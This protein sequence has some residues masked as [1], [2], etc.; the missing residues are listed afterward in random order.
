[1]MELLNTLNNLIPAVTPPDETT[2]AS[3]SQDKESTPAPETTKRNPGVTEPATVDGGCFSAV[4]GMAL[5]MLI[6][7]TGALIAVR[8]K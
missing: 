5:V 1:M 3:G 8:K 7:L 6:S 2:P 4:R